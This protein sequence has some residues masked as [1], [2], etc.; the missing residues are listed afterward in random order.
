[1]RPAAAFAAISGPAFTIQA[2]A[3]PRLSERPYEKELEATDAIPAG[4]I[5]VFATGGL[6]VAGIWG[7]LLSTR[8]LQCGSVGAVIDGGV[9]DLAGIE[10]LKFPTFASAVH[11]AD[12][13]GRME[14]VSFGEPVVCCGVAVHPGDLVMADL[15]GVVVAPA[16]VA[17]QAV[18]DAVA[19][20]GKEHEAQQMLDGGASVR[21]T[22][23]RHGVL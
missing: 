22:Y 21:E 23:D 20:L 19:K 9:R 8:A 1:M 7:E 13:Y 4:S 10:R 15:D 6:F 2:V 16:A 3:Q 5:V 17:D 12:S 11:A 18:R 14:V